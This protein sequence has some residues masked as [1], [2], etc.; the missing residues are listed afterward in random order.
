ML[1]TIVNTAAVIAGSLLG[2]LITALTKTFQL[3]VSERFSKR[4][5]QALGLCTLYIGISGALAG[6]NT[7]I[8]ILSMVIGTL[9]GEALDLDEKINRLGDYLEKRFQGTGK[10][11][12]KEIAEGFVSASLLFCVGAMTIVGSLQSGLTGNHETLFAKSMLDFVAAIVFTSS[13]GI[14]VIFS[15]A[16]VFIYQGAITVLAQ[17][18]SP[19]LT[20]TVIQEMSCA[21]YVIIL[22]LGL[23][24]LG[25]SKF[26]VM[27]FVP[28][29]FLPILFCQFF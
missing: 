29:I 21:G 20:D 18:I 15:A 4:I 11:G 10:D 2:M 13:L 19:F 28:A 7:L 26:K 24:M 12:K 6:E 3:N 14:G 16:F 25:I 17:W 8:L 27:N 23:N 22:A 9:I 1:G 5:M